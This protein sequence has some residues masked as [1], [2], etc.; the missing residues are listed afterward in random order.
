MADYSQRF[1]VALGFYLQ[2]AKINIGAWD[3]FPEL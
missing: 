1:T 2:E 3:I